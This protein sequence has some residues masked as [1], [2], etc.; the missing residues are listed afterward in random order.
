MFADGAEISEILSL[1]QNPKVSGFT[2]NPTLLAKSGV[3]NYIEFIEK[4]AHIANPLPISFEVI[5]DDINEMYNQAKRISSLGNN[6][7]VKI[8]ITNS[9]GVSTSPI[10][11]RLSNEGVNLNIT[12]ILTVQQVTEVCLKLNPTTPSIVSVFA[13]RIADTGNDPIPIM[14]E[15]LKIVSKLEKSELLWASPREI[16]NVV[17]AQ[18]IGCHIITMTTALWD[19]LEI[20]GSSLEKI[21]LDTVRM[22]YNDAVKSNLQI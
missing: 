4:T 17:Q 20:L 2:T 11:Y 19:K 6:I 10:I 8:P 7:Y 18:D 1:R 22:F 15:S 14:K 5:S 13:G 21:S 12:A 9:K 16:L 3:T